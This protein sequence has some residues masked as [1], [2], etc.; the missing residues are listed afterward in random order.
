MQ[1]LTTRDF[2]ANANYRLDESTRMIKIAFS[3]L[4]EE[5]LWKKPNESSNSIA[6]LI[7]HL[8][9]NITQYVISSLGEKEDKRQRDL[10]FDT[11]GGFSKGELLD[12]LTAVVEEAKKTISES[13]DEQFL[14]KRKVQGFD[15]TGLGA[16]LH[17]VEHY[18]YHTGQIALITKLLKNKDLGFYADLDLNIKNEDA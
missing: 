6:N 4:S 12:K 14:K 2:V 10:E 7:L 18:S 15:F 11:K 8:C 13:T 17:A 5:D 1:N 16:A 3:H 9:G